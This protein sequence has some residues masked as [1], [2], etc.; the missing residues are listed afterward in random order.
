MS[1]SRILLSQARAL[2]RVATMLRQR[3]R[4]LDVAVPA[5]EPIERPIRRVHTVCLDGRN[6]SVR[7]AT[8]HADPVLRQRILRA[9]ILS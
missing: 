4:A 8:K 9:S 5:A 3:A 7:W 6:Y 1:A 2:E